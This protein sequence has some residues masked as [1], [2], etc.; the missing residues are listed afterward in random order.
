VLLAAWGR[1]G[2]KGH[3]IHHGLASCGRVSCF[4][5]EPC[6]VGAGGIRGSELE[7]KPSR[8]HEASVRDVPRSGGPSAAV[9]LPVP[10]PFI[11]IAFLA[12]AGGCFHPSPSRK[13][14]LIQAIENIC[15]SNY[16]PR[17]LPGALPARRPPS[18]SRQPQLS[19]AQLLFMAHK[20][21]GTAGCGHHLAAALPTL[22]A[23]I[24]AATLPASAPTAAG[25]RGAGGPALALGWGM[26]PAQPGPGDASGLCTPH[27]SP[28]PPWGTPSPAA[29]RL[30]AWAPCPIPC[31][32]G[33]GMKGGGDSQGLSVP[34]AFPLI[35]IF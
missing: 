8:G 9:A 1:L 17:A 11:S 6:P 18:G 12:G 7:V 29:P 4:P 32:T 19:P 20:G 23:P 15:K 14:S 22:A 13:K 3:R 34:A 27:R 26:G 21:L 31:L 25:S 24:A 28:S 33:S 10:P 30:G 2:F 5:W 16:L 35:V